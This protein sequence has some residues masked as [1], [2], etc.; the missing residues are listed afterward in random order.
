[1]ENISF[2]VPC[3]PTEIDFES[4]D[5]RKFAEEI[6]AKKFDTDSSEEDESPTYSPKR[7]R[8]VLA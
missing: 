3:V 5:I 7:P 1:M 6:L 4:C 2:E 8:L